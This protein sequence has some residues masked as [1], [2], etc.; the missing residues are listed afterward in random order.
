M[1][2][3]DYEQIKQ[4]HARY[5]HSIDFHDVEG[6]ASCF[7]PEGTFVDDD[8]EKS[9]MGTA[10]LREFADSVHSKQ[11]GRARHTMLSS[12]ISGDGE[13]A[14]SLT[15]ALITRDY[16]PGQGK[17]QTTHSAVLTTGVY[18]DELVKIDGNWV[19]ARRC[20]QHDGW[21]KVLGRLRKPAPVATF[22]AA[23]EG[24]GKELTATDHEEIRQ[25]LARYCFTLD[26]GDYD[27]FVECFT[28]DGVFGAPT[29]HD[30]VRGSKR[31]REFAVNVD[32]KVQGHARHSSVSLVIE[33][34]SQKAR[35]ASYG[36]IPM[37]YG[38]PRQWNQ[39][40]NATVG[41]T[42]IYHDEVVKVDGRWRFARRTFSYD[43]WPA[44]VEMLG[45]PFDMAPFD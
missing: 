19:Y 8:G 41:T 42:G 15:Y 43:G 10:Q 18:E 11:L 38:T 23:D 26:F 44:V 40:D 29:S 9:W 35:V 4:R 36:F 5:G 32:T 20:F 27:G 17:G 37:D 39:R 28:E 16:G 21:P 30:P 13:R 12:L 25:L 22:E 14:R 7:A 34:D 6:V 33:G 31:L 2:A 3:L 24:S 1:T 45:R